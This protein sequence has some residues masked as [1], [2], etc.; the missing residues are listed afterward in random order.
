MRHETLF[1]NPIQAAIEC[2]E[3]AGRMA[4]FVGNVGVAIECRL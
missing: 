2:Y 3:A 4:L 1:A